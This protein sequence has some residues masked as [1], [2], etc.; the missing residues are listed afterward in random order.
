MIIGFKGHQEYYQQFRIS[1]K[2]QKYLE[3]LILI[4]LDPSFL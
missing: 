1:F 2:F 3:L 4:I